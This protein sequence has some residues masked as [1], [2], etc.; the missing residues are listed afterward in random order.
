V[1]CFEI[2]NWFLRNL[3][4]VTICILL[5]LRKCYWICDLKC[6]GG[7][8]EFSLFFKASTVALG[9]SPAFYPL[10]TENVSS[11]GLAA[12]A[13]ISLISYQF[14]RS[15]M[16]HPCHVTHKHKTWCLYLMLTLWMRTYM[17]ITVFWDV[18]PCNSID[19]RQ[20]SSETL[21]PMYQTT[22]C[23]NPEDRHL[24]IHRRENLTSHKN[25]RLVFGNRFLT[26]LP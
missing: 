14:L 6:C 16:H 3:E 26:F 21:V 22:R 7:V 8:G 20:R 9:T 19:R 2:D 23:Y 24:Y 13:Y 25:L 17:K 11:Y 10:N 15:R 4:Y 18:T 5:G 1:K 12:R